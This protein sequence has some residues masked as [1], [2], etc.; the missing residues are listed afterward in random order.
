MS[1]CWG[2]L[3]I[4]ERIFRASLARLSDSHDAWDRRKLPPALPRAG[5]KLLRMPAI[6]GGCI[7]YGRELQRYARMSEAGT[8]TWMDLAP[9]IA[10]ATALS[11]FVAH[12]LPQDTWAANKIASLGPEHHVDV[13]SRVDFVAFLTSHCSVTF[14]DIR[15]LQA[16]VERI[17]SVAGT[18]TALPFETGSLPSLSCSHVM[19]H[20]GLGLYGGPLDPDGTRRAVKELCRVMEPGGQ[21]L[22][23][24]PVGRVRS[25]FISHRVLDPVHPRA[26][27]GAFD[28]QE[29][30]AVDDELPFSRYADP[31]DYRDSR[32]ACG[33]Y[34]FR[35]PGS[36]GRR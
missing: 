6:P 14:V 22:V 20:V 16:P 30:A 31:G 25:C 4:A 24:A 28:L 26:L 18:V 1:L 15:P 36:G 3:P 19:E 35:A 23:L 5:A 17:S 32:Y 21:L 33:M 12:C 11:S 10:D 29:F 7:R 27:L 9:Q 2:G 34:C 8:A 13:G